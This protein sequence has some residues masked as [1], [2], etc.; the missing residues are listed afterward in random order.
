MK[1]YFHDKRDWFLQ[2][3]FGLFI[4][5]GI[6]AQGGLHEQEEWR[7]NVPKEK[8]EKYVTTFNPEKFEPA[9]WL[10]LC[11]ECG[12]EYLVFT[13][14]HHDGF[15]MWDTRLTPYN[16]M[17]T[18][19]KKDICAMLAEECHKRK[20]PLQF[21]YSCV[22]WH[23]VTY[24]NL[25]RH[26]EIT[27]DPALHDYDAYMEFLKGQIRELCT[28]YGEIHGIWW[29]MNVPESE[30]PSVN[31]MIRKLQP[32]AVINNRGYGPG[33]YATPERQCQDDITPFAKPVE[34]CESIF[35]HS[36]G[37]NKGGDLFSNADLEE[38]IALYT[39]LGGNFLLNAGPMPD[40]TIDPASAAKLKN[41]GCWYNK[42]KDALRAE[43]CPIPL[44]PKY[45]SMICTGGGKVLN[46]ILHKA[47]RGTNL[48]IAG[49]EV[50]PEEAILLNTGKKLSTTLTPS[51]Y[52][53][54][55]PPGLRVR[56]IPVDELAGEVMVIQLRFKDP[57]IKTAEVEK[58]TLK[59]G[60]LVNE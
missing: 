19:Y 20:F 12:M 17:N 15:C 14:K 3:R 39:G 54:T 59:A 11:Q 46:L 58:K 38:K 25:G 51:T 4:H 52:A 55:L 9:R 24:P 10:D 27:T 34:A 57:V 41:I 56:E 22:D 7:Y 44:E 45:G 8:Y 35:M 48:R 32:S 23:Q 30:D 21:Y 18:P 37:Y 2:K 13:A 49:I 40:G 60:I 43:P 36:W 16:I 42:V 26:H 5:W 31:D 6:Y 29:D 47:P 33:D 50:E 28:N 53:L 1:E